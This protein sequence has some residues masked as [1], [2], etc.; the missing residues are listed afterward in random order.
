MSTT[1]HEAVRAWGTRS[2]RHAALVTAMVLATPAAWAF[3]LNPRGG[4]LAS[5][6]LRV[7]FAPNT[8]LQ[9]WREGVSQ[10]NATAVSLPSARVNNGVFLA[11]GGR[12]YGATSSAM[13]SEVSPWTPISQS[14][15]TGVGTASSPWRG[16][17][18]V[19][20]GEGGPTVSIETSY[21]LPDDFIAQRVTV[22]IPDGNTEA[23]K[24]YHL[25]D[26]NLD[27][28]GQGPARMGPGAAPVSVG[29]RADGAYAAFSAAAPMW[30]DWFSAS[31]EAAF[32]HIAAGGD[33][34]RTVD[35]TPCTDNAIAAQWN[36]GVT[37]RQVVAYH[38]V[39]TA[40]TPCSTDLECGGA[41][42]CDP[43][44]GLCVTCVTDAHCGG[45]T[46]LCDTLVH[47]CTSV[48]DI[49]ADGDGATDTIERLAGTNPSAPDSDLDTVPDGEELGPFAPRPVDTDGDG[50]INALDPDDDDDG[51]ATR[52]EF[53]RTAWGDADGDGVA[54]YL[55]ADDDDDG[56]PTRD[57]R[58]GGVSRDTDGNGVPDHL[59]ADDDHD[60]IL[61]RIEIALDHAPGGDTDGDGV[62]SYRDLDSDGD[63]VP[64]RVE[65][66]LGL[67]RDTDNDGIVDFVDTDDDNDGVA[68][69]DEAGA[70]A[71]SPVD[72]DGDGTPDYRDTDSDN[73]CAP[74]SLAAEV[75]AA[76]LDVSAPSASADANC[77]SSATPVCDTRRGVC[78]APVPP[79]ADAGDDAGDAS[80]DASADASTDVPA[81]CTG[82]TPVRDASGR[83]V[84]AP[85]DLGGGFSCTVTPGA[86]TRD[87]DLA[88][89]S[90]L[91]A[92]CALA[93]K[94][95][96][97]KA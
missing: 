71:A 20:A 59:E 33:L 24:L 47:A 82:A 39:F 83:C 32:A 77:A 3:T 66:G 50:I 25:F 22:D 21:A 9:V 8:Q 56:L 7:E 2:M 11:V 31:S 70:D 80:T 5:D 87:G 58:P 44:G 88:G 81:P 60:G 86:T 53:P 49:D 57:E 42:Y 92:L 41:G 10:A 63:G 64:D 38:M 28:R 69:R 55:D 91:G 36:L 73:D 6:G 75:G 37:G 78:V 27:G 29:A 61:T 4:D 67:A 68:T 35:E 46:P 54:D 90:L 85:S 84:A 45:T 14:A 19:R 43:A 17:T 96:A 93:L 34:L 79:P 18:V 52:D 76:R 12:V 15:I 48:G 72:T 65:M 62:P 40:R 51:I 74:D 30:D 94:R 95:R 26:T 23:V 97:R 1:R 16:V 89:L 13:P